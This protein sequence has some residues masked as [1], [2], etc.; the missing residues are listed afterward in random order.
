VNSDIYNFKNQTLQSETTSNAIKEIISVGGNFLKAVGDLLPALSSIEQS[1]SV[2][3]QLEKF[4]FQFAKNRVL[5]ETLKEKTRIDYKKAP[6]FFNAI[7]NDNF[8]AKNL[9]DPFVWGKVMIEQRPKCV[10]IFSKNC[11]NEHIDWINRSMQY[12]EYI[13]NIA[14]E[15]DLIIKNFENFYNK[16]F[17]ALEYKEQVNLLINPPKE[18]KVVSAGFEQYIIP[19]SIAVLII[20]FLR[21][22]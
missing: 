3:K 11:K 9:F 6:E 14:K 12:V 7:V 17:D 20:M 4:I 15:M 21:P 16:K 2:K 5:R 13:Q 19:I 1:N 8:G 10:A 18:L 22:K